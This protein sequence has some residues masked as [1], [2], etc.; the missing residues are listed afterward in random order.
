MFNVMNIYLGKTFSNKISAHSVYVI[1][2][3]F[4]LGACLSTKADKINLVGV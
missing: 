3:I 2:S 4:N 1:S